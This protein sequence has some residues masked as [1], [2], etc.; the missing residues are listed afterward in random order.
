MNLHF[1]TQETAMNNTENP[2]HSTADTPRSTPKPCL[3]SDF[4]NLQVICTINCMSSELDQALLRPGRLLAHKVFARLP[5]EEALRIAEKLGKPL[6]LR[7]D[8]SLAEI[9][10]EAVEQPERDEKIVGF[11]A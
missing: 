4:L 10:N 7:S 1:S 5:R 6:P 11:A 3:L 2:A 9:F 8:Y